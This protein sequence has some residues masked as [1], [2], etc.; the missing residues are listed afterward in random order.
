LPILFRENNLCEEIESVGIFSLE[1]PSKARVKEGLPPPPVAKN[2]AGSAAVTVATEHRRHARFS[3]TAFVEAL[4][5]KS[6]TQISG[7]S[8]DVSLGGCYVDTLN[9]FHEGTVIRIRLTK[10]NVSFEANA[11]VVFSQIGMGMGVAFL[12]AEKDQFQ[13][14]QKWINQFSG[15]ASPTTPPGLLDEEQGSSSSNNLHKEQSYVL[16]ELVIALMRKGTLTEAEGKA[17]L[18]RLH[19]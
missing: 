10:E 9:P 19:R 12:S 16:N 8:S 6:N 14:Y 5:P 17:M 3:L 18:K 2:V 1:P 7:R 4:D 15:D 11:K 13:I